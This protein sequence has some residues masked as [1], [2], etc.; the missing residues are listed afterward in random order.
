ML[1]FWTA[2]FQNKKGL[3]PVM[4][5]PRFL[6]YLCLFV[7]ALRLLPAQQ[8]TPSTISYEG[9]NV[10]SV[11][12]AGRPDLNLRQLRQLIAQPV[13]KPYPKEKVDATI[14]ALNQ[15]GQFKDVQLEVH[16]QPNGLQ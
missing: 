12:I 10:S 4:N 3:S 2:K 7:L 8:L 11:D 14:A 15:A 6:S 16:P 1:V 5:A 9:Q 13:D